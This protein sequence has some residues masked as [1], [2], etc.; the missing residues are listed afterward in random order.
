MIRSLALR[1][2]RSYEDLDLQLGPGTT[3]VVAPNGVGKTSL[4][5]GLAWGVFGQQSSVNPKHCIRAGAAMAEVEVEVELPC[6]RQLSIHRT[7]RRRGA[8]TATYKMDG[9]P[10]NQS[11]ALAEMEQALG[12]ELS[13]ASRLSMMLGGGHVAA[14]EALKLEGHLHDAFGVALLLCAAET[15]E[16]VAKDA[17]KV[18]TSLR[19]TTRQRIQD[20]HRTGRRDR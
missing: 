18:R 19:S 1:G 13:V 9:A 6:G 5:Y 11:S 16:S 10:L 2:W 4:V 12:I 14:K 17:V 20:P 8:P 15:A 7:A 3:F